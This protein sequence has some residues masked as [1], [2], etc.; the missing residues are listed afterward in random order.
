MK[1]WSAEK[2]KIA[3]AA[4]TQQHVR[5]LFMRPSQKVGQRPSLGVWASDESLAPTALATVEMS[6]P[7]APQ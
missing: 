4:P 7:V 3:P 6:V 2:K 1:R 5:C